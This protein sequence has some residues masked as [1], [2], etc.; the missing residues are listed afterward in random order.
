V[1]GRDELVACRDRARGQ[2]RASIAVRGWICG[3]HPRHPPSRWLCPAR[4]PPLPQTQARRSD[5]PTTR[6]PRR[7]GGPVPDWPTG[8]PSTRRRSTRGQKEDWS[9]ILDAVRGSLIWPCA[10]AF[11]GLWGLPS[12]TRSSTLSGA[13]HRPRRYLL[14]DDAV[15]ALLGWTRCLPGLP[16]LRAA[17]PLSWP[18]LSRLAGPA[19]SHAG[20][21]SATRGPVI[22]AASSRSR[23]AGPARARLLPAPRGGPPSCHA[24]G[25]FLSRRPPATEPRQLGP[26]RGHTSSRAPGCA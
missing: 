17:G 2:G 9:E 19:P 18:C 20:A 14:L 8:W 11:A 10:E 7:E 12:S 23:V 13:A 1:L 3:R 16:A 22:G 26:R 15:F 21:R 6:S 25:D 5:G 24:S 4:P